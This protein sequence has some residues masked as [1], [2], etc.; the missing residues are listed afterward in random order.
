MK[1]TEHLVIEHWTFDDW[2]V[3]IGHLGDTGAMGD[4]G[5]VGDNRDMG[6]RPWGDKGAKGTGMKKI[7]GKHDLVANPSEMA[8]G[9]NR[10]TERTQASTSEH[11]G[12]NLCN[13]H[14]ILWKT[15]NP[16]AKAVR[17]THRN[18]Q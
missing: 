16:T 1:L 14:P 15:Q 9:D 13:I 6:D 2:S 17:R 7:R 10:T 12:R 5:A 18:F 3:G 4:N 11:G 8:L